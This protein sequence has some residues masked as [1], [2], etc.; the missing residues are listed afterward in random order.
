MT[1][2]D[3]CAALDKGSTVEQVLKSVMAEIVRSETGPDRL[4]A[5]ITYDFEKAIAAAVDVDAA[6]ARGDELPLAGVPI[7]IKDNLCTFDYATTCASRILANFLSPYDAT[8]VRRLRSAG[9]VLVGKTNLDE[10]AM[11]ST[12]ESSAFGRTRNPQDPK[13]VTGG[14]SGG[15][16]ATVAAGHVPISL[17]TDT[18]GSVRQPAAFCGVVGFKPT[19]GRISRYG[20]VAYASSLDTVGIFA[21]SA[22]DASRVLH[23]IDGPDEYDATCFG[24]PKREVRHATLEGL[25]V[26]LPREYF[27]DSLSSG[28][29]KQ[30]DRAAEALRNAGADVRE[31]S[32]PHTRF[33]IPAYYALSTTEAASNLARYD[34][35]RYGVRARDAATIADLYGHTR[36]IGLGAEVKRRILLGLFVLGQADRSIQKRA[37]QAVRLITQDF[38]SVFASGVDVLFTPTTATTAFV[39]GAKTDPYEVYL[40]DMLTVAA[41]LAELPAVSIPIGTSGKLPVGG[42]LIAPKW[43]D[44]AVLDA[45]ALLQ[46]IVS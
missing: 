25:V 11:G 13:R 37:L 45:A 33:A 4:N 8:V 20:L 43:H 27:P 7:A 18:A 24:T 1:I 28:V 21:S 35:V 32:L 10:F 26:G 44:F 19:Y 9:A 40:S 5:F 46:D 41:N 38:E 14:S 12:T 17:G 36:S 3:I 22:R 6:I 2:A 23:V 39:S 30:C 29:R 16:A 31:V 15:S 34:G 42:Q